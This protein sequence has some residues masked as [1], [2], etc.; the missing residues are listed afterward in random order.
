[1]TLKWMNKIDIKYELSFNLI[2]NIKYLI[3]WQRARTIPITIKT[4]KPTRTESKN[5]QDKDTLHWRV[6]IQS[7]S[8]TE[9]GQSSVWLKRE[10]QPSDDYSARTYYYFA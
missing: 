3:R 5:L 6:L 8:E 9:E 7:T 10:E 1:M 4:R 2:I